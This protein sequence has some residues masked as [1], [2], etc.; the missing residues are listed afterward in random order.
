MTLVSKNSEGVIANN[1]SIKP[2]ISSDGRFVA[3]HSRATNL[4][5]NDVNGHFDVFVHDLATGVTS[6]ASIGFDGSPTD[7]HSADTSISG[8]GRYVAFTSIATNLVPGDD[9]GLIDLFVRDMATGVTT[10]VSKSSTGEL[11]N[12]NSGKPSISADGRFVTFQSAAS[13]LVEFDLNAAVDVF[14]HDIATGLT[15]RVSVDS[16]G[17][18]GNS[19]S[20]GP[21]ARSISGDGRFITF[22]SEASNLVPDD[23]NAERDIFV[24]DRATG[25]TSLI[26]RNTEGTIGDSGSRRPSISTDGRFVTFHSFAS[27]LVPND[28]NERNDCFVFDRLTET[29]TRVSLATSGVEGN[30]DSYKPCISADGQFVVFRSS[31]SNLVSRDVNMAF[32]IFLRTL[33]DPAAC[34]VGTVGSGQGPASNVLFVNGSAGDSQRIVN[35][36]PGTPIDVFM[37][38][39]PYGPLSARYIIWMWPAL[40]TNGQNMKSRG[41]ILGCLANPTPLLPFAHPQPIYCAKGAGVPDRGCTGAVTIASPAAAPALVTLP[42]GLPAGSRWTLQG[43]IEDLGAANA[44][45]VS[46]TNA[47]FIH[48]D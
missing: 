29:M 28:F 32:D 7:G 36:A 24:H 25:E 15:T 31:A 20:G 10:L 33:P 47:V 4:V 9:N 45:G 37:T 40:A 13:N 3:Y 11:G 38:V 23:T 2:S 30:G 18:E 22:Q 6:I 21:F 19:Q 41:E 14:V 27:N 12:G 1:R 26:S 17:N 35:A 46:V 5:P 48:V 8:D 34:Q 42:D 39:S 44:R 16:A 43:A